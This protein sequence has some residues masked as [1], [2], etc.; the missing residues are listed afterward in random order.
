MVPAP[1][2]LE[3][4][5]REM[6]VHAAMTRRD[7]ASEAFGQNSQ[8]SVMDNNGLGQ[9]QDHRSPIAL[10]VFMT[11]LKKE[12]WFGEQNAGLVVVPAPHSASTP[13]AEGLVYVS[14]RSQGI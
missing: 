13:C 9:S 4:M 11:L 3:A 7:S 10:E 1:K 6:A 5:K 14:H 12:L 8:E 2:E